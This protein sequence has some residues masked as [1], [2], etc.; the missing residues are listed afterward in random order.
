MG[1]LSH[2][3]AEHSRL[4]LPFRIQV[5]N[6]SNDTNGHEQSTLPPPPYK[7]I[8]AGEEKE[9]FEEK[10]SAWMNAGVEEEKFDKPSN[11]VGSDDD[12]KTIATVEPAVFVDASG[13]CFEKPSNWVDSDDD[14]D[15]VDSEAYRQQII[16][17]S[18][19][20]QAAEE[21]EQELYAAPEP[22]S[23]P[24]AP[25]SMPNPHAPDV[26][27]HTRDRLQ[28]R[29]STRFARRSSMPA[30]YAMAKPETETNPF[31][32]GF[33]FAKK[34][35]PPRT[36]VARRLSLTHTIYEFEKNVEDSDRTRRRASMTQKSE[37]ELGLRAFG[38]NQYDIH[39]LMH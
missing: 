4:S 34:F 35:P 22:S 37:F 1:P 28:R 9:T 14:S 8:R 32:G 25:E 2:A 16:R 7:Q 18:R 12:S 6:S 17:M 11:W 30:T 26:R 19:E 23:N 29:S 3:G 21:K 10:A 15:S 13:E 20:R 33:E 36:T 39:R 24:Y 27:C 38:A 31:S 5:P